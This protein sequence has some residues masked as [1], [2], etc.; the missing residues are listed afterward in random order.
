MPEI[1]LFQAYHKIPGVVEDVTYKGVTH[2]THSAKTAASDAG[3]EPFLDGLFS[4][5]DVIVAGRAIIQPMA[6][7]FR[8]SNS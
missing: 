5:I 6:L 4:L 3:A 7:C 8:G 1:L 2:G